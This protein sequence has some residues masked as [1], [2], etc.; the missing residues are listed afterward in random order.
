L[1][2]LSNALAHGAHRAVLI[3]LWNGEAGDGPG[4]T[5][6]MVERARRQGAKVHVLDA[7]KLVE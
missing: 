2:I 7:K 6:D 4:G 5:A 1:W 3:A